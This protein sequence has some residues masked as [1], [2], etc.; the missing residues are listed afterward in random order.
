MDGEASMAD[1]ATVYLGRVLDLIEAEWF[2]AQDVDWSDMRRRYLAR[3]AAVDGADG[4]HDVVD[5]LLA[6]L[7]DGHSHLIRPGQAVVIATR[8][9]TM[10]T[11]RM[12]GRAACLAVP[13][14]VRN[15]HVSRE[16]F[17]DH[18]QTLLASLDA[19][20]PAGWIVDLR[21]NGGG[22]MWPMLAGLGPLLGEGPFGFFVAARAFAWTYRDGTAF[23]DGRPM[24]RCE[25][26]PPV[27]RHAGSKVAVL[28]GPGTASAGEAVG[29]AFK[30]RSGTK[31]FGQP[32]AGQ[33]TANSS[34]VLDDGAILAITAAAMADRSGRVHGPTIETEVIV[35]AAGDDRTRD[36]ALDCAL[37]WLADDGPA[38]A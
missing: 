31:L 4:A 9:P 17:A 10:P 27:I 37:A 7:G 20:E 36:A 11:G 30:G 25:T 18:L 38:A 6:N 23:N 2:R 24:C 19:Q 15:R 12:W 21:Q 33:A 22:D 29:L 16:T 13:A 28:V 5:A 32:T 34:H 3:A 1:A 26:A 8:P 14:F 35:A